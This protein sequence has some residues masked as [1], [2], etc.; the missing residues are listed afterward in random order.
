MPLHHLILAA[1][2][3]VLEWSLYA[4]CCMLYAVCCMLY[5][6]CCVLYVIE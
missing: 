6:A 1:I 3:W 5:A 2:K 4:V